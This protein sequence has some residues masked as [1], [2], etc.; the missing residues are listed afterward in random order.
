[1]T[2][3]KI[4]QRLL[5]DSNAVAMT[6]M[7]L[8][9]P[10]FLGATLGGLEI[11]N[12]VSAKMRVDQAAIYL[13]DNIG[14]IGDTATLQ[15]RKVYENDINDILTGVDFQTGERIELLKNGRVIVSSLEL[16]DNTTHCAERDCSSLVIEQGKHFISWQRCLGKKDYT[17]TYGTT[18]TSLPDGMGPKDT[19]VYAEADGATIFVEVAYEYQPLFTDS[20]VETTQLSSIASFVIRHDRDRTQIYARNDY[21]TA[22]KA[23]CQVYSE[24]IV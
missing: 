7:A 4:L 10:L 1:M 23:D 20:I 8:A 16:F 9:T 2:G 3:S 19:K 22:S 12:Y 5:R 18:N 15:D 6:E 24:D 11:V 14:R 21:G 13:A 17:S